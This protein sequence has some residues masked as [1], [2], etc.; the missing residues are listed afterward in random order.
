MDID[1]QI[2]Y[3]QTG[4]AEDL[5]AAEPLLEK[6]HLRHC[7]FLAHWAIEKMLKALV[8]PRTCDV[9]PRID[10]L[11]RLALLAGLTLDDRRER[12]LRR[13]D[14]YRLEDGFPDSRQD[15]LDPHL[16][17]QELQEAREILQWL[18]TRF[19]IQWD[20]TTLRR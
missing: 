16:A 17:T 20:D 6:G 8:T 15:V 13:F 4:S 10:N 14:L 18:K 9:P 2:D 3:W 11:V 1:R 5:A 19:S 12:S 7:L